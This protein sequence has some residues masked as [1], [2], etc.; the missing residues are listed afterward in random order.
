MGDGAQAV[1]M[2]KQGML[3]RARWLLSALMMERKL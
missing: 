3:S 1:V 2:R